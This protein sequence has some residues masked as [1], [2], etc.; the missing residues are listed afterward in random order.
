MPRRAGRDAAIRNTAT[1]PGDC[2]FLP[3]LFPR[4]HAIGVPSPGDAIRPASA[5]WAAAPSR[6]AAGRR[7]SPAG[8]I[9]TTARREFHRA[10]G[11]DHANKRATKD[12]P[13]APRPARQ[14]RRRKRQCDD[15]V[16]HPPP[17]RENTSS[18]SRRAGCRNRPP[19]R[20]LSRGC[21]G[22]SGHPTPNAG[23]GPGPAAARRIAPARRSP[24][25]AA[26]SPNFRL[27]EAGS[28]FGRRRASRAARDPA[29][30]AS[31]GASARNGPVSGPAGTRRRPDRETGSLAPAPAPRQAACAG[32]LPGRRQGA[33]D[34]AAPGH[35]SRQ[36][37]QPDPPR[38]DP[39][40][41]SSTEAGEDLQAPR[42]LST[43]GATVGSTRPLRIPG[44]APGWARR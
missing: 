2:D 32:V 3:A 1:G 22:R 33:E 41:L 28:G 36:G 31:P 39:H 8:A 29:R 40:P 17:A 44:P 9:D 6:Q 42:P 4:P 23:T 10:A 37:C 5:R 35:R 43:P 18:D 16:A 27:P 15:S 7:G 14:C 19:H 26:A 30:T 20:E 34:S 21:R 12:R 13:C 24:Y 25:P 38:P 11:R